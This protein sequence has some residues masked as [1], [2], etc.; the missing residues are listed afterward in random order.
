ML[1]SQDPFSNKHSA[2]FA[3]AH[4]CPSPLTCCSNS[5]APCGTGP[6]QMTATGLCT[7]APQARGLLYP[8]RQ[9][10]R[11]HLIRWRPPGRDG[12]IRCHPR[13]AGRPP[14]ASW[15]TKHCYL[16]STSSRC[17]ALEPILLGLSLYSRAP[18]T[19][20]SYARIMSPVSFSDGTVLI[21]QT[22]PVLSKEAMADRKAQA[23][24]RLPSPDTLHPLNLVMLVRIWIGV[25]EL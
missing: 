8:G 19:F 2:S 25:I 16:L 17:S 14:C 21:I 10:R 4:I 15:A 1:H 11:C 5:S 6:P 22:V 20:P 3:A 7:P 24:S 23:H 18:G 12:P 13:C 9:P